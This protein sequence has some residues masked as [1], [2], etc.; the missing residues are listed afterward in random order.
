MAVPKFTSTLIKLKAKDAYHGPTRQSKD[1][2]LYPQIYFRGLSPAI[3]LPTLSLLYPD[4]N[5]R[6]RKSNPV[7]LKKNLFSKS[8][9]EKRI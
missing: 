3:L 9:I 5:G 6:R 4:D 2:S 8:L 7:S 1:I